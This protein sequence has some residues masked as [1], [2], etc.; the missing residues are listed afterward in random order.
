MV[1]GGGGGGGVFVVVKLCSGK[2]ECR[3]GHAFDRA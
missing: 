1:S 2:F 3:E